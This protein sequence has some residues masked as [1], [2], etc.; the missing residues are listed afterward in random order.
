MRTATLLLLVAVTSFGAVFAQST[1]PDKTSQHHEK[2]SAAKLDSRT[3]IDADK[4]ARK[5]D[6]ESTKLS[7]KKA[8]NAQNQVNAQA[9]RTAV[10]KP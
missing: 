2:P 1:A 6:K 8:D 5:S 3:S 7:A 9:Y 10:P 4:A